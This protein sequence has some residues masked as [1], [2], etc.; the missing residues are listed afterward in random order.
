MRDVAR[1]LE[2]RTWKALTGTEDSSGADAV[3]QSDFEEPP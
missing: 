1:G 2:E 3:V